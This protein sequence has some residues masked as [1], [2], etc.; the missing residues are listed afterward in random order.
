M[1]PKAEYITCAICESQENEL[2]SVVCATRDI[3]RVCRDGHFH[4]EVM[5]PFSAHIITDMTGPKDVDALIYFPEGYV[6]QMKRD[7]WQGVA[8]A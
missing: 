8:R 7:L 3:V 6:P 2:V 4:G 5:H 1:K